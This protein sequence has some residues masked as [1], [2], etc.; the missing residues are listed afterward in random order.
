MLSWLPSVQELVSL[1]PS[2]YYRQRPTRSPKIDVDGFRRFGPVDVHNDKYVYDTLQSDLAGLSHV[3]VFVQSIVCL[4]GREE[5]AA[6][7][8]LAWATCATETA[9]SDTCLYTNRSERNWFST[10]AKQIAHQH[11]PESSAVFVSDPWSRLTPASLDQTPSV[12]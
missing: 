11:H 3:F 1:S 7:A 6:F 8:T 9:A 12:S 10:N 2:P 4:T 5:L